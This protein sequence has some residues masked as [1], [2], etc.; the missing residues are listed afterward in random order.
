MILPSVESIWSFNK[1]RYILGK[2]ALLD[3]CN[4]NSM[5]G[6]H[7]GFYQEVEIK[8]KSREMMIFFLL[9]M[10]NNTQISTLHGFSHK[11]YFYSYKK[12]KK[13]VFSFK[14][15]WPPVTYDVISKP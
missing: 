2:V 11:I 15:A 14:M 10:R 12:L 7:L 4:V 9:D 3:A 8:L 13:H 5:H 6:R 1:M